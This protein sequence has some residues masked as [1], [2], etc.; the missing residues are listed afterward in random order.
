MASAGRKLEDEELVSYILT[1]LDL[2]FDSVVSAVAAR[3]EPITVN[4]L[5]TQLIS[6]E[7]RM[8]I[9]GGGSN[10]LPTWSSRVVAATTPTTSH[11]V[12]AVVAAAALAVARRAVVV[13][14]VS[15]LASS[16]SSAAKDTPSCVASRGSTLH[17]QDHHRRVPR[18]QLVRTGLIQTGTWTLV[19]QIMSLE[20]W[21]N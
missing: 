3:V 21:R 18:L 5:Y 6:F 4:E 14:A 11:A 7:Q 12:E 2:E 1:R 15:M 17:F 20:N 16:A 19:L 13:V 9:H 8:E 10:P